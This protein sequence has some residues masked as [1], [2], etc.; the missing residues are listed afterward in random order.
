MK[1]FIKTTVIAVIVL[2]T[3]TSV[4]GK[5]PN[6]TSITR[7]KVDSIHSKIE[8]KAVEKIAGKNVSIKLTVYTNPK[9]ENKLFTAVENEDCSNYTPTNTT[10]AKN[11]SKIEIKNAEEN[12]SVVYE[13]LL[14]EKNVQ[15]PI[16]YAQK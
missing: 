1:N 12:L 2:L 8:Y 5:S 14:I 15:L 11:F 16:A 7:V 10:I 3:A 4:S 9:I 6:W 13:D